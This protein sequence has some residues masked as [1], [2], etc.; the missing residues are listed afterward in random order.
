[1]TAIELGADRSEQTFAE[2]FAA[3]EPALRLALVATYGPERGR[4]AT[5][6]ALAWAW[7]HRERLSAI[8]RPL[9][10]LYRVGQSRARRRLVRIPFVRSDWREPHVEPALTGALRGLSDKQ[11]VA[12]VLVHG[13]GWT[14]AEVAALQGVTVSTVQTHVERALDRLR[15]ELEVDA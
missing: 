12:V 15:T 8:E 7:E 13:Y 14:L 6:D 3:T 1:M 5:A 10:Y 11:R 4:E 2:F 9:A